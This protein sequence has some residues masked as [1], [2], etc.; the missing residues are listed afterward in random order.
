MSRLRRCTLNEATGCIRKHKMVDTLVELLRRP[1]RGADEIW[2][3][4]H[5]RQG[6]RELDMLL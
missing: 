2:D 1:K 5:M 3:V 6:Q 4:V